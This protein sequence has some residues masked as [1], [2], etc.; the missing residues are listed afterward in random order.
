MQKASNAIVG[1]LVG[2]L[3]LNLLGAEVLEVRGRKSGEPHR[4]PVNPVTVD[5]VRYLFA[6]R[7][8]TAWVK[9]IRVSAEGV[10]HKGR[11][12]TRIR[13][14]EIADN[15]KPPI[16][17]AYLARWGWQVGNL[18]AAPKDATD[19]QL[20]EIAPNHPVFRIVAVGQS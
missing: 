1:F 4:V 19:A 8:E 12:A 6:P 3:R 16:I 10:L 20:Q 5:G 2:K 17:R 11:R 14:E 15:G 9:N 7:G 18:V 13:V